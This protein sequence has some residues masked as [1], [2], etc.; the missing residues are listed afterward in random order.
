LT[1]SFAAI[2]DGANPDAGSFTI[3]NTGAGDLVW[4]VVSDQPWLQVDLAGGTGAATIP[5]AVNISG[6][7]AGTYPGQLTVSATGAAASP[8]FVVVT[9]TLAPDQGGGDNSLVYLPIVT[10]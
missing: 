7:A 1:L 6:L 8:Q 2:A 5:V 4:S 10:Q 9:L 3:A